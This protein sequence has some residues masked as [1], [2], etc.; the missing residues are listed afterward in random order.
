MPGSPSVAALFTQRITVGVAEFAVSNQP[1]SVLSTYAFGSCVG[2]V[3]LDP[4]SRSG[5]LLHLMLPDSNVSPEKA[6]LQPAMFADTGIP[7]LFFALAGVGAR[8]SHLVV[9][10][11]GGA[12]VLSGPDSFQIGERNIVA[13]RRILAVY[14][15]RVIGAE[16]GGFVNR[17]LHLELASGA[18]TVKTPAET[19][20]V[21]MR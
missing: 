4:I 9:F 3:A 2:L 12:S 19:F 11:A 10:L 14:G 18:L 20:V 21:A 1:A 7:A 6:A 13:V 8:R 16:L 5:G 17:T 15:C